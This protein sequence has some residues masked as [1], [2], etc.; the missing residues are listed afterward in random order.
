MVWVQSRSDWKKYIES[1]RR[2][3]QLQ[4]Q[5]QNTQKTR[6][7]LLE[8]LKNVAEILKTRFG[9]RR[10]MVFG[11]VAHGAWFTPDSDIDLAVEGLQGRAYWDAWR[12]VEDAFKDYPIDFI[13]LESVSPTFAQAIERYGI[14]L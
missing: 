9:A 7:H 6:T 1:A 12:F 3:A 14:E 10:V 11:A 13:D 4:P 2:R 8:R 5:T